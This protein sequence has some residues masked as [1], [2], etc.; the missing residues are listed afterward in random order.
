MI[1]GGHSLTDR[2]RTL[3]LLMAALVIFAVNLQADSGANRHGAA[4]SPNLPP[5]V[6]V[7]ATRIGDLTVVDRF[8]EGSRI[9]LLASGAQSQGLHVLRGGFFAAADPQVDFTGKRILFAARK[10]RGDHWQIWEM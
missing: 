10:A 9:A 7:Q 8:P 5:I 1:V 3:Q 6:F 2:K 4:V